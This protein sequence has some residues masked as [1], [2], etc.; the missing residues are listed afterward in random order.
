MA[1]PAL[2]SPGT[3]TNDALDLASQA[4]A[5][6]NTR[7]HGETTDPL[8][9]PLTSPFHPPRTYSPTQPGFAMPSNFQRTTTRPYHGAPVESESSAQSDVTV[10]QPRDPAEQGGKHGEPEYVMP[11]ENEQQDGKVPQ[12]IEPADA[13]AAITERQDEVSSD[14]LSD[15][16][17]SD[18]P[19]YPMPPESQDDLDR[20]DKYA[21]SYAGQAYDHR[22]P[23]HLT[24]GIT[25]FSKKVTQGITILEHLESAENQDKD[26]ICPSLVP[27]EVEMK[28][29]TRSVECIWVGMLPNPQNSSNRTASASAQPDSQADAASV[30]G[31]EGGDNAAAKTKLDGTSNTTKKVQKK[32]KKGLPIVDLEDDQLSIVP[33]HPTAFRVVAKKL[34][35]TVK[36]WHLYALTAP[37]NNSKLCEGWKVHFD[38]VFFFKAFRDDTVAGLMKRRHASDSKIKAVIFPPEAT[39]ALID[40]PSTSVKRSTS[41]VSAPATPTPG[42]LPSQKPPGRKGEASRTARDATANKDSEAGDIP[43]QDG[44]DAET[45]ADSVEDGKGSD[46]GKQ[47]AA[48]HEPR[49]PDP[50]HQETDQPEQTGTVCDY[51]DEDA[52]PEHAVPATSP[53]YKN[54][55]DDLM[56]CAISGVEPTHLTR[57]EKRKRVAFELS[58]EELANTRRK[59]S[60][61]PRSSACARDNLE[62]EG[63][64]S[65]VVQQNTDH[66]ARKLK[67]MIDRL[68]AKQDVAG[69]RSCVTMV[70]SIEKRGCPGP[71]SALG[72]YLSI[73]SKK[74]ADPRA[75]CGKLREILVGFPFFHP[76]PP[77]P[78]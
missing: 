61:G 64:A 20:L 13:E 57:G 73:T 48:E 47:S 52:Y 42:G 71:E 15:A 59:M 22:V 37:T 17:V 12:K 19:E 69:L 51:G 24:G 26:N 5:S 70:K 60:D 16:D 66:L 77:S 18:G 31:Q 8:R 3:E 4:V 33:Y 10:H 50:V 67:S 58:C 43:D 34:A 9:L 39:P 7:G 41:R 36:T 49:E 30:A 74:D 65:F 45:P 1:Q 28:P 35:R 55:L 23:Q 27:Q 29:T 11:R 63:S 56:M 75:C 68:A 40:Q 78:A 14:S 38:E 6:L 72:P 46:A 54:Y 32:A 44:D 21:F 62:R 76:P 25:L 53:S 2:P